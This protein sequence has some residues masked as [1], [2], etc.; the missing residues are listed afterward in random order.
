MSDT[1]ATNDQAEFHC[2]HCE[3]R[4][5]IPGNLPPTDGPCPHCGETITSPDFSTDS[6][7]TAPVA[8]A[9]ANPLMGLPSGGG[10]P[11]SMKTA[12]SGSGP[13]EAI[14]MTP[15]I[16]VEAAPRIEPKPPEKPPAEDTATIAA[17]NRTD[18][19]SASVGLKIVAKDAE[20]TP[21]GRSTGSVPATPRPG[22]T[23]PQPGAPSGP[24]PGKDSGSVA[25]RLAPAPED[26]KLAPPVPPR[27]LTEGFAVRRPAPKSPGPMPVAGTTADAAV[28]AEGKAPAK[29]PEPIAI[30]GR[31][32]DEETS[33]DSVEAAVAMAAPMPEPGGEKSAPSP[34]AQADEPDGG[35]AGSGD[36]STPVADSPV[37][38][39]FAPPAVQI[40]SV[41]PDA[42]AA[43]PKRDR[44]PKEEIGLT[45]LVSE[46]AMPSMPRSR[47]LK[48]TPPKPVA[49]VA[50]PEQRRR[51]QVIDMRAP[52]EP[53]AAEVPGEEPDTPRRRRPW[54]WLALA[55]LLLGLGTAAFL[56]F[57]PLRSGDEPLS[58]D[59]GKG[60]P[61]ESEAERIYLESGWEA[62]ARRVLDGFLAARTPEEIAEHVIRGQELLPRIREFYQ[63][64]LL[65][66]IR[67][68]VDE[69][70]AFPLEMEDKRRGIF[71][72]T[73]ERAP[74]VEVE[75]F[76]A[77]E[78]FAPLTPLPV[79]YGL[80][81]PGLMLAST[82]RNEVLPAEPLRV[83]ALFKRTP[84][85]LRIDWETFV[86]TKNRTL[87]DFLEVPR[88]GARELFRVY[89]SEARAEEPGRSPGDQAYLVADPMHG[90]LDRAVVTVRS[91]APVGRRLAELTQPGSDG[92]ARTATLELA[93][94]DAEPPELEVSRF[95]CWEF[96]GVGGE[97]D[98]P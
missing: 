58:I 88:G 17:R 83:Q 5:L 65:D 60:R 69:F 21:A 73:L 11:D 13:S 93:W 50:S 97:A 24:V 41:Q 86:Q 70:R 40:R 91:D 2:P 46:R 22:G 3:G 18:L 37:F 47:L 35:A 51:T 20:A 43:K 27:L 42:P 57:G 14:R 26:R 72:L 76:E 12:R 52:A 62:D 85:G 25:E 63:T 66:S 84:A 16:L 8:E 23:G 49:P 6:S 89:V 54:V 81:E 32:A 29:M 79:R 82:Q 87:R 74:R 75:S 92:D 61:V 55:A 19:S 9:S 90:Q 95:L 98:A 94:S 96:L 64:G 48:R 53:S 15:S 59:W 36:E 1:G 38:S 78:F 30:R 7:T 71:M 45:Q 68:P 28:M 33:A 77:D 56:L 31:L 10:L 4:I 39:E 67:T 34:P 80:E 44:S